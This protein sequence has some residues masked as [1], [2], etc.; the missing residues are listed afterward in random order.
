[1]F[2]EGLLIENGVWPRHFDAKKNEIAVSSAKKV[3][4]RVGYHGAISELLDFDLLNRVAEVAGIELVLVGPVASFT[5]D[6]HAE[7]QRSFARL[8]ARD[9]V[10]YKGKVPY[11]EISQYL[12]EID[13]GIVPFIPNR[14]TNAVSP[15]K[16]FEFVAAQKPVLATRTNSLIKFEDT[17]IVGEAD[18]LVD[19]L[20]TGRWKQF[21]PLKYANILQAHN[22]PSLV[23]PLIK[24]LECRGPSDRA[25]PTPKIVESI[26]I[27][28]V[29]FFDWDGDKLFKGGAERYVT[30]LAQLCKKMGARVRLLQNANR[31]FERTFNGF[32][33]IGV[34]SQLPSVDFRVIS[35]ALSDHSSHTDLVIVS[36]LELAAGLQ[37][38]DQPIISINHGV[39]WDSLGNR[40]T[41]HGQ[42]RELIVDALLR[43]AETI[44]VDTNFIN[45]V[46]T[47]DWE[48]AR[49]IKYIPNYVDLE[50]FKAPDKD[51]TGSLHVLYPRRLYRARGLDLTIDSF[52]SILL[53]HSDIQLTF[54][55]QADEVDSE[56]VRRFV[57]RHQGRVKWV[58]KEFDQ[59]QSVY[60]ESHIVLIPTLH[61][62]RTS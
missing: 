1:L 21:D 15:L 20:Q 55:G 34:Y 3:A 35:K 27:L 47:V 10:V 2:H 12:G 36:P 52:E 43:S 40:H 13:V 45:W 9:N 42:H 60:L 44:A 32:P 46:R 61:S 48:L 8:T 17:F 62:E 4:V 54:C 11:E 38:Q 57:N 58:E 56:R 30:D 50:V 7:L 23:A 5:P 22:W 41:T 49:S 18:Q 16:L 25:C 39:H 28:N 6:R 29:N 37:R 53:R 14:A 19:A 51:F 33:V 59:M 26:D 24:F 31:P